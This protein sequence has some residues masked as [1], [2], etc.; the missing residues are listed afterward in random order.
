MKRRHLFRTELKYDFRNIRFS[1][2]VL[3]LSVV[4]LIVAFPYRNHL[5]A[6]GGSAEGTAWLCTF[7]YAITS[8][9]SLLFF[10]LLAPIA[11]AAD[12]QEELHS[13]YAL[14]LVNRVGKRNYIWM[15]CLGAAL[16]GGAAAVSATGIATVIFVIACRDIPNL[17]ILQSMSD[18]A[19]IVVS[20]FLRI[21]L[22]GALWSLCGALAAVLTRNKYLSCAVPFILYYV[23][24]V[25]QERYYS[26]YFFLS[27]KQWVS[28]AYYGNGF[29]FLVLILISSLLAIALWKCVRGRL[30]A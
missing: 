14:F 19:R 29:C 22:N 13:R 11:V 10:P 30:V 17:N 2:S 8:E 24:T 26:A 12:L 4:L 5:I 3:A 16:T 28:P 15:K 9:K 20:G 7:T 18:A 23:L 6:S 1:L 21:F 27:P 25:F